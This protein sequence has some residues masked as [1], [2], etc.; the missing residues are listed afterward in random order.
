MPGRRKACFVTALTSRTELDIDPDKLRE[1]VVELLERHPLV[2]EGT[3]QLALQHRPEAT[4]PWY[5]GCQRQSLISSDSDFTEV[6]GELRD[7]YL[8]E[9]F[10][11]LPFKPIRTRI[12]ALDPKYCYSVHRDLTPRYHLAVTTSEHARFV[13]IEHD[14]VLHIPADGDL[15]YVDTRQLHSAFNG[16]DD[17]RIHIVFGTDGESK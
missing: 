11:R 1:S 16:G 13:F 8:G 10:D 7:T 5:E 6:H 17:M 4:D 3:R 2:F 14:K 9:V 15:Y 12:M